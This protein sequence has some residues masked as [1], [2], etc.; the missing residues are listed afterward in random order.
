MGIIVLILSVVRESE[1]NVLERYYQERS[2]LGKAGDDIPPP[3]AMLGAFTLLSMALLWIGGMPIWHAI[4][5][6]MTGLSTGGFAVT[7]RA[8]RP[9]TVSP[10]RSR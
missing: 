3:K 8:S 6:G 7:A 9:T 1:G 10:Y 2:P 4:N 5:H